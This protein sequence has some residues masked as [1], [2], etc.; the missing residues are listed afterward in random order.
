M[1]KFKAGTQSKV[2]FAQAPHSNG[3]D[4]HP[5]PEQQK[6]SSINTPELCRYLWPS[7]LNSPIPAGMGIKVFTWSN[8]L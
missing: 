4:L 2:H 8:T 5:A 7:S 1:H 3:S 6:L